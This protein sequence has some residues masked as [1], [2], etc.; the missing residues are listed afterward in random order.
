MRL[1][2]VIGSH[3]RLSRLPAELIQMIFD[4]AKDSPEQL[5]PFSDPR[6]APKLPAFLRTPINRALGPWTTSDGW[7]TLALRT[8]EDV[9]VLRNVVEK[10]P[11]IAPR[12]RHLDV[13]LSDPDDI[14][15]DLYFDQLVAQLSNLETL[16]L[17]EIGPGLLDALLNP[18]AP[19]LPGT[20]RTLI[21]V[22]DSGTRQDPYHPDQL[23]ELGR[24]AHL[25]TLRL[26]LRSLDTPKGRL[27]GIASQSVFSRVKHLEIGLPYKGTSSI[28]SLIPLFPALQS[29]LVTSSSPSPDLQGVLS[30][31]PNPSALQTLCLDASPQKNWTFS[32][33][34]MILTSLQVLGF[35]GRWQ[36]LGDADFAHLKSLPIRR[37]EVLSETDIGAL[38]LQNLITGSNRIPTLKELK[39]DN[40]QA[41]E[42]DRFRRLG[43]GFT[44]KHY[45]RL[46]AI[47]GTW[48]RPQWTYSF[49]KCLFRA[50]QS[51]A[52][53]R[54]VALTGT[55]SRALSIEADIDRLEG[56][57]KSTQHAARLRN[58]LP[59]DRERRERKR[60]E[61]EQ[62][63]AAKR[64]AYYDKKALAKKKAETK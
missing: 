7:E 60:I 38:Q 58:R 53:T 15:F 8:T 14:L 54:G 40:L 13:T 39:L 48:A 52:K 45:Q 27:R 5:W 47:L 35:R 12:I 56:Y 37:I 25:E 2:P 57:L 63:R 3:D 17:G 36:R 32:K 64:Q 11:F 61:A 29:L 20:L 50:L 24:L 41:E 4:F 42:G 23:T 55:Y 16:N 6:P 30:A 62:K 1:Q 43:P 51:A 26:D 21:L 9:N 19:V 46:R 59:Y 18:A 31:L 44:W 33:S 22:C 49:S 34:L 10:R 28:L